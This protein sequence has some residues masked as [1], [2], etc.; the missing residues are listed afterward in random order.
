MEFI[1]ASKSPRRIEILDMLGFDYIQKTSNVV[2]KIND[3]IDP[4]NNAM[5]IAYQKALSIANDFPNK[6]IIAADT[7]VVIDNKILGKP[8]SEQ[9]VLEMLKL[10]NN[11]RH[12]VYSGI[13]LINLEKNIKVVD[14]DKTEVKFKNNSISTLKKYL[15]SKEPFGKA[16]AYAIQGKGS[17]LIDYYNGSFFNVIGLPIKLL[18]SNLL[19]HFN[20]SIL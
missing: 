11:K 2:E 19:K 12:Y 6:T 3:K 13:A 20:Y 9:E 1:L 4:C 16:G 14:Y 15:D 7:I 5:V 18:N 8:K 10:L 17:L